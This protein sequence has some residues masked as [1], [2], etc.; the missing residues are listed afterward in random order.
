MDTLLGTYI[1]YLTISIGL[2]VWVAHTLFRNG[3]VFLVEIFKD[4]K[5]ADAV[6]HLLVVGFY[7]I[8][9]GYV[10]LALKT[11][12]P[13]A[14]GAQVLETLSSKIGVV[15]LVLGAM[16][17]GNLFILHA[18]RRPKAADRRPP[19]PPFMMPA[20]TGG[21]PYPAVQ[22]QQPEPQSPDDRR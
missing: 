20:Y 15:M 18:C 3:R 1:A 9:L 11:S 19:L 13:I 2:T 21:T 10:S 8:N 7:L 14:G 6:N 22:P 16:H 4:E 12:D 17:F 5:L